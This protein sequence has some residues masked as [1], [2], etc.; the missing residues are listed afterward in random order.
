MVSGP[1]REIGHMLCSPCSYGC[2]DSTTHEQSDL[3]RSGAYVGPTATSTAEQSRR[4]EGEGRVVAVMT[5]RNTELMTGSRAG[6][7]GTP[8]VC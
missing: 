5:S 1:F 8:K 4:E 6:V 7:I 3:L 2:V